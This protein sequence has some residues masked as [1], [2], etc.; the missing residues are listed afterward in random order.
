MSP[1]SEELRLRTLAEI[2]RKETAL[3]QVTDGR[4]FTEEFSLEKVKRLDEELDLS[5][6]VDAF[7]GRFGRL[8]DT[9]GDKMLPMLL[10]KHGENT[11]TVLNNLN[12][13]EKLGWLSSVD[14]WMEARALRNQMIHEYVEDAQ[15]LLDALLRGHALVQLLLETAKSLE[16]IL[17]EI[18]KDFRLEKQ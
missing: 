16:A 4:L 7:V 3:L 8:Q 13:A 17:L 15:V 18:L 2:V 10:K 12:R 6:R 1:L 11:S 5:E 9:L 14:D